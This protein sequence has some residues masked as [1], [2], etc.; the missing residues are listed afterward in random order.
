MKVE[1]FVEGILVLLLWFV[2]FGIFK[3]D[4]GIEWFGFCF[5]LLGDV[6]FVGVVGFSNIGLLVEGGG[7]GGSNGMFL[8]ILFVFLFFLGLFFDF[9]ICEV[10]WSVGLVVFKFL[11]FILI[12][13]VLV[14]NCFKD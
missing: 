13:F 2:G 11:V 1:L 10:V 12:F 4:N 6:N 3:V 5:N 9:V 7:D 8:F 14:F